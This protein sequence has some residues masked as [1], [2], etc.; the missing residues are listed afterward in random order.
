MATDNDVFQLVHEYTFLGQSC[1]NVY[2]YQRGTGLSVD[3]QALVDE[4]VEQVLP[5]ILDMQVAGAVTTRVSAQNLF[6]I[7]DSGEQLLSLAGAVTGGES[8]YLPSFISA[9]FTLARENGSTRNGQKRIGGMREADTTNN[10]WTGGTFIAKLGA[11]AD[12]I[13]STLLGTLSAEWF[14]PVIVKRILEGEGEYR[15]P[16]TAA[17]AIIN[18]VVDCVFDLDVTTQNSRKSWVGI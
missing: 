1:S 7:T 9:G 13:A 11:A 15:L 6:E 3:A 14:F 2:F 4:W 12:A 18:A 8:E 17:E 10:V 16:A 5:S